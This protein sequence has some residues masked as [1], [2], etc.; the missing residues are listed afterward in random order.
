[1]GENMFERYAIFYT[2]AAGAFAD[3]T[4][5]WLGWDSAAGQAVDHPVVGDLDV[6]KLTSRPRKYGFHAT[7]KAPFHLAT[8]ATPEAL[9]DA[10]DAVALTQPPVALGTLHLSTAH[11]FLALR[12]ATTPAGLRDLA[13]ATVTELDHLRAP[14]SPDD[15]ARRRQSRLTPRQDEYLLN[16]G[17]PYVFEEFHFHM[18]L[19]GP[20]RAAQETVLSQMQT[21][22]SPVLPPAPSIDALT[23]MGQDSQGMFHQIHRAR[24]RAPQH[25]P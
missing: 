25:D 20:L 14:L 22:I 9:K 23:L 21:L 4:A 2:P 13:A 12:P 19:T 1:M 7:L 6:A 17:Y 11:G 16:W 15:I 3:F 24:L 18:T 10:V 5:A 8:S